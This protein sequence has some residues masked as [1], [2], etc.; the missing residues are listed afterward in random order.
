MLGEKQHAREIARDLADQGKHTA[1]LRIGGAGGLFSAR[2]H[3]S[4]K[5]LP[6]RW[7]NFDLANSRKTSVSVNNNLKKYFFL[8][9][10]CSQVLML[11][12]LTLSKGDIYRAHARF[13][14]NNI[15]LLKIL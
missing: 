15:F 12:T 3:A 14:F 10:C 2:R 7:L 8:M 11:L 9:L 13:K 1:G 4:F 5:T 6:A